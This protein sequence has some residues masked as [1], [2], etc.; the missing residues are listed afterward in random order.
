MV[1]YLQDRQVPVHFR[2]DLLSWIFPL[3]I[4]FPDYQSYAAADWVDF[5]PDEQVSPINVHLFTSSWVENLGDGKFR[6]HPLPLA[7]QLAPVHGLLIDDFNK[8]H[9]PDI[10]LTGNSSAA[11]PFDGQYDAFNGLLLLGNSKGSFEAT[12]LSASGFFV[13]GEG[14]ALAKL[15]S[16]DG[17]P[18][19][20]ATQSN[21]PLKCF[22]Y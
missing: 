12:T 6:V 22:G 4:R 5:F 3:R 19:I 20:L 7:A 14:R 15:I 2:D 9:H 16:A 8:D 1:H 21:G 18:I 10:L 17:K 11:N 13:P